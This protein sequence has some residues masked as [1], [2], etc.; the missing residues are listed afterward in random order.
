MIFF[1]ILDVNVCNLADDTTPFAVDRCLN[2]LMSKLEVASEKALD[3]FRCNGMKLNSGKCKLLVS[4]NKHECMIL[5]IGKSLVIESHLVK[6]L[7][8]T[9]ESDLSFDSHLSIMRKK[10][11]CTLPTF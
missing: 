3:W 1:Y 10:A 2:K 11:R 6:L 9:I 7:G 8:V 4:G 5:N